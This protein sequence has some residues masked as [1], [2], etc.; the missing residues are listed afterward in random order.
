MEDNVNNTTDKEAQA[1]MIPEPHCVGCEDL[2]KCLTGTVP[3]PCRFGYEMRPTRDGGLF[4]R[5]TR[6]ISGWSRTHRA[7]GEY[8]GG[9]RCSIRWTRPCGHTHTQSKLKKRYGIEVKPSV[10]LLQHWLKYVNSYGGALMKKKCPTCL[11]AVERNKA[12][13]RGRSDSAGAGNRA[14]QRNQEV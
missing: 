6:M 1:M 3:S 9:K 5:Y 11:R 4:M 10:S 12:Q 7:I 8:I 14:G 13:S 2:S